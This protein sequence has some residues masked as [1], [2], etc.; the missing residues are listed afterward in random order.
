MKHLL[1]IFCCGV[2]LLAGI[3]LGSGVASA[4]TMTD[5]ETVLLYALSGEDGADPIEFAWGMPLQKAEDILGS[6]FNEDEKESESFRIVRYEYGDIT[7][8]GMAQQLTSDG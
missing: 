3:A 1:H 4:H 2:L 5:D 8:G 6:N 7:F